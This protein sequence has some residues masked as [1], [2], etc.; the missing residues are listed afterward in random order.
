MSITPFAIILI[1]LYIRILFLK[2]V[3]SQFI[4]ACVLTL[5]CSFVIYMGYFV[6]LPGGNTVQYSAISWFANTFFALKLNT[7]VK[8]LNN[9]ASLS[10]RQRSIVFF[11]CLLL[12]IT[13]F[14]VYRYDGLIIE[15]S[16]YTNY[17]LGYAGYGHIKDDSFKFGYVYASL[18]LCYV[19]YTM[20]KYLDINDFLF[21]AD[22]FVR[23]SAISICIGYLEFFTENFFDT[24]VV[25]KTTVSFFGSEGAQQVM[26]NHDRGWSNIQAFTKE[27]S[28]FSTTLLYSLIVVLNLIIIEG[29]N[30]FYIR[31]SIATFLLMILNRSMSSYVYAFLILAIVVYLNPFAK[32][33]TQIRTRPKTMIGLLLIMVVVLS[34]QI[35]LMS[36]SYF[37]LRLKESLSEFANFGK[38][39][40]SNSSEGLRYFG[41][42]Y[43]LDIFS[44]RP[45]F[46]VGLGC[47]SCLSGIISIL[48]SIGFFG[49]VSYL[50]I[51]IPVIKMQRIDTCFLFMLIVV[52]PNLL[53]NDL[54]IMFSLMIPFATILTAYSI[55]LKTFS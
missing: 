15:N 6:R 11:I 4:Y 43:C 3:K 37:A 27:A 12:T 34:S 52:A 33:S 8:V 49:F 14:I 35:L 42:V 2:D 41:M 53:L 39:D 50:A 40:F 47:V 19:V 46:G 32:N 1:V 7:S 5:I 18:M 23:Y 13:S 45:L 36:D 17:M 51:N 16:D 38:Y 24:L 54:N 30:K 21:I 29:K 22:K 26:F 31:Y 20:Y 9:S 44:N 55:N 10:Y 25:T 28:M 48:T